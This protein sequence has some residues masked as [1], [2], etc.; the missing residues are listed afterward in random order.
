VQFDFDLNG[1]VH[2]SAADRGSGKQISASVRA[3]HARLSPADIAGAKVDLEDLDLAGWDEDVPQ[4]LLRESEPP[5]TVGMSLETIGLLARGQRALAAN[6]GNQEILSAVGALEAAV[7]RGD[8]D[9][10]EATSE[11]LLDLLY[12]LDDE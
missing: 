6:P 12:D 3:A 8:A 9:A 1:I 2:V 4:A 11:A 10:L 7:R 5:S